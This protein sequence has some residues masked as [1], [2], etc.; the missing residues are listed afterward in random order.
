MVFFV[1]MEEI[2]RPILRKEVADQIDEG[3]KERIIDQI[4]S[5]EDLL[6]QW[7]FVVR[8][9]VDTESSEVLLQQIAELYLTLRGNA[10]AS[11]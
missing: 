9:V 1:M 8:T 7:C 6:Y 4:L 5:D 10:F 3:T 2:I 11:P